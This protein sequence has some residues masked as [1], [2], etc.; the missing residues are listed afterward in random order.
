M[1]KVYNIELQK[2]NFFTIYN[3]SLIHFITHIDDH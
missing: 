3:T 2:K 1:I